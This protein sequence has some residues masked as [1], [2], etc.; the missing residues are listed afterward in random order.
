MAHAARNLAVMEQIRVPKTAELV[1]ENLR[2]QIILG[3]LKENDSLPPE[4]ELMGRFGISRPTLREALRILE[5]ESL[6]VIRR[7]AKGGARVQAPDIAVAARY[8]GVLL[9]SRGTTLEDVSQARI[10]IEPASVRMLAERPNQRAIARLREI[11]ADEAAAVDEPLVFARLATEFHET[12]VELSGNNTL[13]VLI[14]MLRQIMAAHLS[15]RRAEKLVDSETSAN[16]GRKALKAHT[17]LVDLIE[18]GQP[19]EAAEL[20]ARHIAAVDQAI[21]ADAGRRTVLD[22]LG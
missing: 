16:A 17:K 21:A 19:D 14:G 11:L 22:L 8:A 9:Q 6:I 10:I 4:S 7:G 3:D 18:A 5:S 13:A 12:L 15:L 1:A 20:W 2:R